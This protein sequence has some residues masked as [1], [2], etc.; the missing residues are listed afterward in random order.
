[1][2]TAGVVLPSKLELAVCVCVCM[3][4]TCYVRS[5]AMAEGQYDL[6]YDLEC[7]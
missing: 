5:A 6:G 3:S 7:V 4:D 2:R 1:M